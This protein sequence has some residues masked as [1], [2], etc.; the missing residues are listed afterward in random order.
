MNAAADDD[1][2]S[3][4]PTA[5]LLQFQIFHTLKAPI[6]K[7][8][9]TV[10]LGAVEILGTIV[11][12]V[13]INYTG[14]RPLVL[15]STLGVGAGFLGTATYATFL[16]HVP[17]VTVDNIVANVSSL[18]LNSAD[19]IT[20][21]NIPK[22]LEVSL[23]ENFKNKSRS[24]ETIDDDY[25]DGSHVMK[26]RAIMDEPSDIPNEEFII[27]QSIYDDFNSTNFDFELAL[28][29]MD[30]TEAPF[31]VT[32]DSDNRTIEATS[33][34]MEANKN[35]L[36]HL[37]LKIPKAEENR[38]LWV[39]LTL[40]LMS[41]FFAHMGI[42]LIP[43]MLIGEVFPANVRSGASGI[44]GG[45]GYAFAFL[46]NKLFLKMLATLTLPGTFFFYSGV[47]FVGTFVLY[48]VL[49]ETEGRSLTEI[50]EHFSG[51]R[52]LNSKQNQR[53]EEK[54]S[55]ASTVVASSR[56]K[57][58]IVLGIGSKGAS[59]IGN[60]RYQKAH[61][62]LKNW[63]GNE[64]FQRHLNE[65][66]ENGQQPLHHHSIYVQNPKAHLRH[67]NHPKAAGDDHTVFSTYL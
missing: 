65:R 33:I 47:A 8:Y 15:I 29:G 44:S 56:P 41:A 49:P 26:V 11:C 21:M 39:P 35:L 28:D 54:N 57:A 10:L 30:E 60:S 51:G 58:D 36:D 7:Y 31:N 48:Y 6:D 13:L 3:L 1:V 5:L 34:A 42:K 52:K 4:Q 55:N 14:K 23:F 19:L 50:E 25:E 37:V 40:L 9:A 64:I 62:D 17:G 22:I 27:P 63:E 2:A 59:K 61:V 46:A 43:W 18:D 45:T 16:H 66:S 53:D 24:N 12:V 20:V 38:F 32:F 67:N